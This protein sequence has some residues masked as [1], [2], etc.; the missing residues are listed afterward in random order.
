MNDTVAF[1][2]HEPFAEGLVFGEGLRWHAGR[3][4]VSDMLGRKVYSYT[5]QGERSLVAEVPG[6]PNGLGFLP[7]G[8]LVIG[9][10]AD[11]RLLRV[12]PSGQVSLHADLSAHM[13]G[14]T[15]DIAIDAAGRVYVDDV[16]YRVFE[17]EPSAPGR[18]L[19]VQPDGAVSVIEE[20][21]KFPNGMWIAPGG[22]RLLFAEGRAG[23]IFEYDL[24]DPR[25]GSTALGGLT[26]KR[27]FADFGGELLDGMCMDTEGAVWQCQPYARRVVRVAPG[28]R[29]TH[30][31]PF[32]GDKP[33][34]CALG[35]ADRRKLFVVAADYT[36]ERMAKDDSRAALHV[37]RVEV[38][39]FGDV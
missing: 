2:S 30:E 11:T 31:L 39:G 6:R 14:Y 16:G 34:A 37:A 27:V 21:L 22:Q 8:R 19:L 33:V 4:W 23:R 38:P 35:G 1:I 32:P 17:G 5:E 26:G 9:S 10:M 15:G 24:V 29:I 20:G 12:E 36:L 28:G 7:D 3:L 13:T 18:L 25:P